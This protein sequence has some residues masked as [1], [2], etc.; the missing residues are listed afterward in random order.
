MTSDILLTQ[1]YSLVPQPVFDIAHILYENGYSAYLVGGSVRDILLGKIPH[2]FDIATDAIPE[3]LLFLFPRS[4]EVGAKFGTVI[5]LSSRLGLS[6][7][8]EQEEEYQVTTFRKDSQYVNGR[9][10]EHVDFSKTI[11]E[12]LA[13]RDFTINAI[14][15]NLVP[16]LDK[17]KEGNLDAYIVDPYKGRE[18]LEKQVLKAVGDPIERM[19]EDGLRALRACRL[20]AKLEF[21]IEDETFDAI[22]K[23]AS[24]TAQLSMERVRDE[25]IKTLEA[26]SPSIGLDLMR[27]AGLLHFF[28]PELLEGVGME[29]NEFH[30]HDVYTHLLRTCD[31][32]PVEIRLAALL[33]DIGKSRTKDGGHF[34]GHEEVGALMVEEILQ[35]LKFPNAIIV[36]ITKLIRLHMFNYLPDWSDAAVRRFL[37]KVG[38]EK[39]LKDLFLLR[40]AD[41][42]ANP[43]SA[44]DPQNLRDLELRIAKVVEEDNALHIKDLKV[45]GDDIRKM[46]VPTGPKIGEILELLLDKVIED[47]SLNNRDSLLQ[48]AKKML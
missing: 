47:P 3:K 1:F 39:T 23:S 22:Q 36:H 11:D 16:L 35:R 30:E 38:D 31:I 6:D 5:V 27:R 4:I 45:N 42:V 28:I 13:R 25:L 46:G 43:K 12:D 2:D 29:Q 20:A 44:Y 18:D 48:L 21:R 24:I 34:Y 32:A 17:N 9:W 7:T 8:T 19:K 15:V 33:H 14:A 26:S 41:A 37:Q 40:I 10:P